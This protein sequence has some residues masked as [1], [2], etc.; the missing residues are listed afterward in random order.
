MEQIA[1]GRSAE[2]SAPHFAPLRSGANE[3]VLVTGG[4]GPRN[5][6]AKAGEAL[7]FASLPNER[8]SAFD[9]KPDVML[10]IGLCG[11]LTNSLPKNRIVAYTDCL[12]TEPQK[13]PR[14]CSTTV[15]NSVV[16]L[17]L[18][19]GV[20]CER[21]VGIM[22]P[23]IAVT[24]DDR[25]ALARSG[26]SAVDMET[27]EIL[28]VAGDVGI[29]AAVLRVVSDTPN[30]KMPDFNRALNQDGAL[31]GRKALRIALGSPIQTARLLAGNKRAMSH[32][33]R[34]LEIILP[35]DCF[36]LAQV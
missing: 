26:A 29:P 27:Y 18:S 23:R 19:H 22:S 14:R 25:L 1:G 31:D 30:T 24:S 7:G 33:A 6:R 32:L 8:G 21:V 36:S 13:P 12:S 3:L 28:A 35:A 4:M 16:E 2:R 9:R 11:G 10:V 5:A 20:P 15:T 17:L 34:A